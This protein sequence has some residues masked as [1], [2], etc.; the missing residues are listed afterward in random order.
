MLALES[1]RRTHLTC[2]SELGRV[3]G[4]WKWSSSL[5][6]LFVEMIGNRHPTAL[7]ILAHF[8]ALAWPYAKVDWVSDGWSA[9]VVSL[10]DGALDDNWRSWIEWPK[11]S[12]TERIEVD[13]MEI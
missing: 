2:K 3:N 13:D 5:P 4:T 8:A 1:L 6:A 9:A 10:V 7:V 11:R 12:V